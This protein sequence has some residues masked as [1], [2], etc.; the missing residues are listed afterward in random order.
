[1]AAETAST[2]IA[3]NLPLP[4]RSTVPALPDW[5][6]D[7]SRT[8]AELYFSGTTCLFV[9]HGNVHDL[10]RCPSRDGGD[11]YCNLP[12]F[13]ATQVFGSWDV[14]VQYDLARGLRP[15]A[16]ADSQRLHSMMQYL[17]ARLGDA[18][19]WPRDPDTVLL[20]L[21]RLLERALLEEA[22]PRRKSLGVI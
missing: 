9:I 16:G 4:A 2:P 8:L 3:E 7:W 1:G 12:E 17:S 15:A 20:S 11:G 18:S 5:Y 22:E 19:A 10:I 21:D 6:P 13:L 14:V